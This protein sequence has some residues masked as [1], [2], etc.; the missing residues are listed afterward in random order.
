MYALPTVSAPTELLPARRLANLTRG[1]D[2]PRRRPTHTGIAIVVERVQLCPAIEHIT[3]V[4]HALPG[5][6]KFLLSGSDCTRDLDERAEHSQASGAEQAELLS[7]HLTDDR[8]Q[9]P[10]AE[11]IAGNSQKARS[12]RIKGRAGREGRRVDYGREVQAL[13]RV[14]PGLTTRS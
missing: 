3:H 12:G 13:V 4:L 5:R 2:L 9:F 14:A 11:L 10:G 6:E 7:G 8:R 1:E